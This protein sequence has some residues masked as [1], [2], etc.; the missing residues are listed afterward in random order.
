MFSSWGSVNFELSVSVCFAF[1][2]NLR[3]RTKEML[4]LLPQVKFRFIHLFDL[5]ELWLANNSI[6][7]LVFVMQVKK[8]VYV[9]LTRYAEEQQDLA[10]LSIST[11]QRALKVVKYYCWSA[12]SKENI[13]QWHSKWHLSAVVSKLVVVKVHKTSCVHQLS[14][15]EKS[16][17]N[18]APGLE[19]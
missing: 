19:S 13:K 18:Y 6:R 2:N 1:G 3:T 7:A 17:W 15:E 12:C 14:A 10:L 16:A 9:Y 5:S 11:F 8:L 4:K